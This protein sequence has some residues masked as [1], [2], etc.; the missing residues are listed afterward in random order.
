MQRSWDPKKV[1]TGVM[2]LAIAAVYMFETRGLPL[3]RAGQMGPGYFPAL[4]EVIL[5]ILG[6]AAIGTGLSSKG[7]MP[8]GFGWRPLVLILGAGLTFAVG[9]DPLGFVPALS[10]TLLIAGF[11][12]PGFGLAPLVATVAGV[13]AFC[14][15]VF[16]YGVSLPIPSFGPIFGGS[17]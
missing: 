16:I 8:T 15:A 1:A 10:L 11:A 12:Y 4:L 6:L 17:S 3:G 14:W 2:F 13:T 9:V 5:A 7:E